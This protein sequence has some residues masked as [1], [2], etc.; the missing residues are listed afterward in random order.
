M[1]GWVCDATRRGLEEAAF[2]SFA[3][4]CCI[5]AAS[6]CIWADV[7]CLAQSRNG[8]ST[9]AAVVV[10]AAA[11]AAVVTAAVG[12]LLTSSYRGMADTPPPNNDV[13]CLM[14]GRVRGRDGVTLLKNL[15]SRRQR[16]RWRPRRRQP[17][18][19]REGPRTFDTHEDEGVHRLGSLGYETGPSDP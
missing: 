19:M 12:L 14:L 16:R 18:R 7:N 2:A 8:S 10:V 1:G 4:C 3:V 17:R 13:S 15:H 5:V 6:I 9:P 11:G